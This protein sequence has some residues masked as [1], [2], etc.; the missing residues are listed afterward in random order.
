MMVKK[1]FAGLVVIF[2]VLTMGV[3]AFGGDYPTS[4]VQLLI[5]FGAGGSADFM[6]R[7]I[8]KAAEKSLG[9]PIVAVNRPGAGGGIMYTALKNAKPDGYTLGWSS[10]GILTVT[11]IGNV[12]FSYDAFSHVCRVGYSALPIAVRSDSPWK[13]FEEFVAYAKG[14]PGKIK[15][16]NAGTGSATHLVPIVME[17]KLDLK[18]IHVPL[19]AK[20]RVPSL[21]GGEVEAVCVPLPEIAPQVRAGKARVL[22]VPSEKRDPGFPDVPTLKEMGHDIVIELFRSISVVKGTPGDV[23]KKIEAAFEK[24]VQESSFL[25]ISKKNSFNV[26]YMNSQDFEAYVKTKN[27]MIADVMAAAGLKK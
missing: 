20:R 25:E 9:K 7:A 23:I 15:I 4:A 26:S 6:G 17:Q 14:N 10:T 13:T 21:L 27:A 3:T 8:A 16:G 22:V 1:F 2:F 19:G 12:P 24:G 5:P 18:F 11:N